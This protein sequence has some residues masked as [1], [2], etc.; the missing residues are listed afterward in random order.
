MEKPRLFGHRHPDIG[1]WSW[2]STAIFDVI[3]NVLLEPFRTK[4]HSD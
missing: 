3:D 1:S 2:A 4:T